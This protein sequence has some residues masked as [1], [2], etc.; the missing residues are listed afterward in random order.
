[1]GDFYIGTIYQSSNEAAV[2]EDAA[3]GFG[4]GEVVTPP[5]PPPP[6]KKLKPPKIF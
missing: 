5:P 2:R 3:D 4:C 1:M 6:K